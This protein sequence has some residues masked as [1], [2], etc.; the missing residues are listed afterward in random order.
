MA[1]E[2]RPCPYHEQRLALH[3][4]TGAFGDD[5]KQVVCACGA[6]G[7]L[8]LTVGAAWKAWDSRPEMGPHPVQGSLFD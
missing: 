7:P 8:A 1:G 2:H 3:I 6:R 4:G 5:R